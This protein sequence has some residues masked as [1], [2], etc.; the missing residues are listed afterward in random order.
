[1]S[2]AEFVEAVQTDQGIEQQQCGAQG[3]EGVVERVLVAVAVQAQALSGDHVQVE[4]GQVEAAVAAQVRDALAHARQGVLGEV[5]QRRSCGEH[6]EAVEGC[7]G[8]CDRDGKIESEPRLA[9]LGQAADDA[10][11]SGAPQVTDQPLGGVGLRIDGVHGDGGQTTHRWMTCCTCSAST[12]WL[13]AVNAFSSAAL[14][15]VPSVRRVPP[16]A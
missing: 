7:R 1:M 2:A 6:L 5:D 12:W 16:A 8:G 13:A 3:A 10:H 15:M 11:G 14:A 9:G 4:G